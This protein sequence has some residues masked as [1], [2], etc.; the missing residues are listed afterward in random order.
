M[1]QRCASD[2][3]D[4]TRLGKLRYN[5]PM[6]APE[7]RAN[8]LLLGHA[9]AEATILDAIRA[10]RMHHAWLIT[11]PEGVGKATLAYRFARRLLAGQPS[12]NSLALDPDDPVF[13]R[14]AAGSHADEKTI[15]RVVNEKTKRLKTQIAVDDVRKINTFM[16]LTPAE[17]GW[18]VV[19][20]DGAEDLNQASAN[21]L[22]KILEE[23]PPR[24]ILLLVCSAP[25]RLPAT[26]RSR[27]RRLRLMPLGDEPMARLLSLYL[28]QLDADERGRLITLAEGSPGR[29]IMLAEDEGLKIA[30]LVDKLLSDLPSV[31]V[32]RGYEIADFLGRSETGFS[33][34]MDLVRAGVAAAV[35]DSVRGQA[36]PEQ[37]RLVELRPL[38]AWGELWQGLT[39]LQDETER[40]ALDKRQA[41]V[42]GVGMLSGVV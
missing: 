33:T 20:V 24:A 14:V 32:S 31:P 21:A 30:M 25:G 11:G 13:R 26:I 8:P 7:P 29:A 39:R 38:D 4:E 37:T 15:E 9:D 36:D 19:V 1:C 5:V 18:R 17:G 41:I 3:I 22:L 28:P 27:C 35:R 16:S 6:P 34:F 12:G 2:V 23:P 42:A 40:F 10:G